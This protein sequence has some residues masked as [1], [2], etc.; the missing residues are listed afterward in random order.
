MNS[1]KPDN[2]GPYDQRLNSLIEPWVGRTGGLISALR[3]VQAEI[4]FLPPETETLAAAAFNLTRAEVKGVIS[5]YSDFTRAPKGRTVIRLCAAEACQAQ[6]GRVLQSEIE[7]RFALTP[8]NTSASGDLT[9]EHVYC[10]GLCSAG[11]AAMVDDVLMAKASA[12]KISAQFDKK[13]QE[14][15]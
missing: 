15:K 2:P 13:Q 9:L 8:G 6:G 11:P 14:R 4:G 7:K 12:N 3:A 5:F 1:A 10:L